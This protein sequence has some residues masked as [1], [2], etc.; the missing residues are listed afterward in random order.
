[1]YQEDCNQVGCVSLDYVNSC[2]HYDIPIAESEYGM[3]L[4]LK[5]ETPWNARSGNPTHVRLKQ[6][7]SFVY[8][9]M[10]SYDF[11]K[12]WQGKTIEEARHP[13]NKPI[14][15]IE[16]ECLNVD[17]ATSYIAESLLRKGADLLVAPASTTSSNDN[18]SNRD[19]R[20]KVNKPYDSRKR[21]LERH[22]R[23][24]DRHQRHCRD[25]RD[26]RRDE[27][28]RRDHNRRHRRDEYK[29]D[30]SKVDAPNMLPDPVPTMHISQIPIMSPFTFPQEIMPAGIYQCPPNLPIDPLMN[31]LVYN[32]NMFQPVGML[33]Q[34][35]APPQVAGTLPLMSS[36]GFVAPPL[37]SNLATNINNLYNQL[38]ESGAI[39]RNQLSGPLTR[40]L[41]ATAGAL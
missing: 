8:K 30:M 24:E 12:V 2:R 25:S 9:N 22:D 20:E 31:S 18:N 14:F 35:S 28:R 17:F 6:R 38:L 34:I 32:Q 13:N 40:N 23:Y 7:K 33:P 3:R 1:M 5:T 26:Y 15:E 11:T 37:I 41:L 19:S 36:N 21:S 10:F 16:I 29:S 4:M 27:D 39:N